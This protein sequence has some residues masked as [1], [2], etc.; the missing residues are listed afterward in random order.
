MPGADG[1][2]GI[3]ACASLK[4]EATESTEKGCGDRSSPRTARVGGTGGS[5]FF[6]CL[7]RPVRE[8]AG[9]AAV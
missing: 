6:G 8:T 7:L 2:A 3:L 4:G 1:G 9:C 5:R